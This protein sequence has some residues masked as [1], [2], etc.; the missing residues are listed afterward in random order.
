MEQ[1]LSPVADAAIEDNRPLAKSGQLLQAIENLLVA[2]KQCRQ[3]EDSPSTSRI[4]VEIVRLCYQDQKYELL[5]EKLVLLSKRRGQLRAVIRGIIQ[6]CVT[7]IDKIHNMKIKLDLIETLR[8]ISDGKIFVENERARL[9][10]IL[11]KIK[12]DEGDIASAA[13]ILQDLQVE[14][15]STMEKKEKIEFFIDQMRICMNNKDFIRAQL[16]ANKVNRKTLGEEDMGDLKIQFYEQL[17]RYYTNSSDYLEITRCYLSIYETPS[18][19]NS[20]QLL[21]STLKMI[22]IYI[23]LSPIGS[24]QNDL[25]NRVYDYKPLSDISSFK[26]LLDN[27]KVN[28]LIRWTTF[29][30]TY[31]IELNQHPMFIQEHNVWEDLRKR[32]IEH[33]IRVISTYYSKISTKRLSELLDL[34]GDDSEKFVSDLVTN[35]TIYAR[36]DRPLGICN[37]IQSNDPHKMLNS[38]GAN[39]TS[40]LDLVEKTNHLIQ[41][42]FMIHKINN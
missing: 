4:A 1:D 30:E 2:E 13:K 34:S 17:I 37:F 35:K 26:T 33:N 39:I 11:S 31:K 15:Y 6:E 8:T 12:E 40:L 27:F 20:P 23:V 7:Y 21:H 32:V 18:V 5:N 42:E 19:Q 25:I 36:I 10:K 9:T 29:F 14:T 28:E 22:C 41:R 38:W 24:E 3:A 16:I